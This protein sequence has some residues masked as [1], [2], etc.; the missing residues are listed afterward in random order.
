MSCLDLRLSFE[1]G[2]GFYKGR[3]TILYIE[4]RGH[5]RVRGTPLPIDAGFP[6]P[7]A[8]QY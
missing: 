5:W 1:C 7:K 2:F 8:H 6:D 3:E 4:D